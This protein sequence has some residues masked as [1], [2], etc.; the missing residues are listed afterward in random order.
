MNDVE[1]RLAMSGHR[2]LHRSR[3]KSQSPVA[4]SADMPPLYCRRRNQKHSRQCCMYMF[5]NLYTCMAALIIVVS[6]EEGK[7]AKKQDGDFLTSIAIDIPTCLRHSG[8]C[9]GLA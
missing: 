4:H 1:F 3:Y 9:C 5:G 7:D 2:C 6:I 8:A